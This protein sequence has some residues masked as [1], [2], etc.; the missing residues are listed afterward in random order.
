MYFNRVPMQFGKVWRKKRKQRDTKLS[1]RPSPAQDSQCVFQET[2]LC[3]CRRIVAGH[4][5]A[6]FQPVRSTL[7]WCH[8]KD[9]RAGAL[10]IL[11]LSS[12]NLGLQKSKQAADHQ[13][14]ALQLGPARLIHHGGFRAPLEASGDYLEQVHKRLRQAKE[15]LMDAVVRELSGE[16]PVALEEREELLRV[17]SALTAF[18]ELV[19]E[20]DK[21]MRLQ[22]PRDG[23][24]YVLISSD[25]KS[26]IQRHEN[27]AN[28]WKG[29]MALFGITA[30]TLVAG[31]IHGALNQDKKN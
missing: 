6:H 22:P 27:S 17:G 29:L 5:R 9:N 15:G 28:M 8:P 26:F 20:Q 24:S 1:T 12:K 7:S 11:E 31:F 14:R 30:F 16:K 13:H 10:E 19:L 18:G 2:S 21:I 25:Y 4:R 3:C 23:R